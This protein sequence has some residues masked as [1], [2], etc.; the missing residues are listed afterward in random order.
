MRKVV[1]RRVSGVKSLLMPG[2]TWPA[3][4]PYRAV[5]GITVTRTGLAP[6]VQD[7]DQ[8]ADGGR[9]AVPARLRWVA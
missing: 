8:G 6:V 5:A 7:T 4:R 3:G 1:P 2:T 9:T